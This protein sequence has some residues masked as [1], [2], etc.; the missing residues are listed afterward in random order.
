MGSNGDT[1]NHLWR[2]FRLFKQFRA[3]GQL[4]LRL[5]VCFVA[6][7]FTV[8]NVH[9]DEMNAGFPDCEN[10]ATCILN[11]AVSVLPLWP[12][13]TQHN[14][15]PEGSDAVIGHDCSLIGTSDHAIGLAN[16]VLIRAFSAEV[17]NAEFV[18]RDAQS[19]TA[20]LRASKNIQA[21]QFAVTSPVVN[22]A[23]AIGNGFSFDLS[24]LCGAVSVT[25][26]PNVGFI[27]IRD[28]I[29]TDMAA[30]A[31][32][33]GGKLVTVESQFLATYSA[34]VTEQSD[35]DVDA[36]FAIS[37]LPLRRLADGFAD[38]RA[39]QRTS[40]GVL[41]KLALISGEIEPAAGARIVRVKEDSCQAV[42]GLLPGN[43]ILFADKRRFKN[44]EHS[45]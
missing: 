12:V 7:W 35:Y 31:N 5:F 8:W 29:Q 2:G 38:D 36:G 41:A 30:N 42:S 32:I 6:L 45:V 27:Q 25:Q 16:E 34:N 21:M 44:L 9:A 33:F 26:K 28:F 13:N 20:F 39:M 37:V 22:R 10:K 40:P 14:E 3:P 17:L 24:E 4:T 43:S 1:G 23:Y 15:E 19:D 11:C 18:L